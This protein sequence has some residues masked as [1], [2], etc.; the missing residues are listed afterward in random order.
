MELIPLIG[1]QAT[2]KSTFYRLHFADTHVRLNLDMLRTRTREQTIF[3]ACLEAKAQVVV[4]NTNPSRVERAVYIRPALSAGFVIK[5]YFFRSRILDALERN[6]CRPADSRVPDVG[7]RATRN[8]LE[9]PTL[10][11]GFTSLH[12][13]DMA[14]AG[15]FAVEE[16]RD[17]L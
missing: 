1:I 7:I 13:V 8:R 9:F 5:G 15:A 14:E 16:W 6:R 11:E 10:D 2:G 4:D 3:N 17:E 12:F